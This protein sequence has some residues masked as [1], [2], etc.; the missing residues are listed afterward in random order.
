LEDSRNGPSFLR[1]V[2]LGVE[3][4]APQPADSISPLIP[5]T[6][7][8]SLVLLSRFSH[9]FLSSCV[10]H[11]SAA[12]CV[13]PNAVRDKAIPYMVLYCLTPPRFHRYSSLTLCPPPPAWGENDVEEWSKRDR[14]MHRIDERNPVSKHAYP[15]RPRAEVR[16]NDWQPGTDHWP[17]FLRSSRCSN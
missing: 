9:L 7:S 8:A 15:S 14:G 13:Q 6:T 1:D 16:Q 12:M 3:D 17:L 4:L 11:P 5:L 2:E 10:N